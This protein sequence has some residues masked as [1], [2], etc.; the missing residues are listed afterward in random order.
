MDLITKHFKRMGA[1]VKVIERKAPR[2]VVPQTNQRT[3]ERKLVSFPAPRPDLTFRVDVKN[4][5]RGSYFE[6]EKGD[7]VDVTVPDAQPGCRHLL[8]MAKTA[9]FKQGSYLGRELPPIKR[10]NSKFLLGHDERDWFVAAIPEAEAVSNVKTAMDALKPSA[11]RRAL[12]LTGVKT[13]DRNRRHNKASHRQGEWFFLPQPD[14]NVDPKLI[15]RNE[16]IRRGRGKPHMCEELYRTGGITVHVNHKYPN[17]ITQ[18]AFNKLPD[19]EKKIGWRVMVRDAGVYVRGRIRHPDHKT[20][21][22][23]FWHRV[24]MN[25][26]TQSRAMRQVAF[27]D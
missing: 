12:T 9:D 22:L 24:E 14:M 23:K 25:T 2:V 10:G 8:L 7:G 6:I 3:G 19:S 20:L 26:E 18:E 1:R 15:L 21:V 16:P 27:L 11:V 13:K 4:D 17:G 5:H